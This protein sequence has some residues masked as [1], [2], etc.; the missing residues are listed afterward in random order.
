MTTSATSST[1]ILLSLAGVLTGSGVLMYCMIH[2]NKTNI[3]KNVSSEIM[4]FDPTNTAASGTPGASG[5]SGASTVPVTQP[6]SVPSH[7]VAGWFQT[8]YKNQKFT[9]TFKVSSPDAQLLPV[10]TVA[11][12]VPFVAIAK[13]FSTNFKKLNTD[14]QFP[15]NNKNDKQT[16]VAY[17]NNIRHSLNS[18][19]INV[20]ALLAR[21]SN[22]F[23]KWYVENI[24]KSAKLTDWIKNNLFNT[25]SIQ[26]QE[27]SS[28]PFEEEGDYTVIIEYINETYE[29]TEANEKDILI[30]WVTND[31]TNWLNIF[32]N[33]FASDGIK[34]WIFEK[35]MKKNISEDDFKTIPF[36]K[37]TADREV[38]VILSYISNNQA[39]LAKSIN[40]DNINKWVNFGY[41]KWKSDIVIDSSLAS[42][43][44]KKWIKDN[45]GYNA[46]PMKSDRI[47]FKSDEDKD[48]VVKYID[49]NKERFTDYGLQ[50]TTIITMVHQK[51]YEWV[52]TPSTEIMGWRDNIYKKLYIQPEKGIIKYEDFYKIPF[53][54]A[55]DLKIVEDY[56][57]LHKPR[58]NNF[59]LDSSIVTTLVNQDYIKWKTDNNLLA[60]PSASDDIK[61]WIRDN[62]GYNSI[63]YSK[64][65]NISFK[66]H[67][68]KKI[69]DTYIDNNKDRLNSFLHA[70]DTYTYRYRN[71]NRI[72]TRD[73]FPGK[74]YRFTWADE[75]DTYL[76]SQNIEKNGK[77][78]TN[79]E[80][81]IHLFN[82]TTTF[83]L[84]PKDDRTIYLT[85][86]VNQDYTKWKSDIE[87]R[88]TEASEAI[89][90][91]ILENLGYTID[92]SKFENIGFESIKDKELIDEYIKANN[93][94]LGLLVPP[95][96]I[97]KLVNQ[98]YTKWKS[99]IE[100]RNNTEASEA[101]KKWILKNLGYTID[102]KEFDKIPFE[103]DE[104]KYAVDNY[105]IQQTD[106]ITKLVNLEVLK[107]K[108]N[109]K[110]KEVTDSSRIKIWI[111][112]MQVKMNIE[113]N[114]NPKD[115]QQIPFQFKNDLIIIQTFI[116]SDKFNTYGANIN[117]VK[118]ERNILVDWELVT[119]W[120]V[121]DYKKWVSDKG[122]R[123]DEN[124]SNEIKN[125]I[126]N[127]LGYEYASDFAT[128]PLNP[129]N[130]F[131]E[132]Q[133]IFTYI[134]ENKHRLQRSLDL[135]KLKELIEKIYNPN[136][137]D[138]ASSDIQQI[139]TNQSNQQPPNQS[140]QQN[141]PNP[142][143]P[144]TQ[145]TNQP[146]NPTNQPNPKKK[147]KVFEDYYR[148]LFNEELYR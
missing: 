61:K 33:Q 52:T 22:S 99:D 63:D 123:K 133:R 18:N 50:P 134:A 81:L 47:P 83:K 129:K 39:R 15:F 139:S 117:G 131:K 109:N 96:E 11:P 126:L 79:E 101:I 21:V 46:D 147:R 100:V 40:L 136:N 8:L 5:S 14:I 84:E 130:S 67:A 28:I 125:W 20:E 36:S 105:I 90:K 10:T 120:V 2:D 13:W 107:E 112:D 115:F 86:W 45:L 98:D 17:I 102:W 124:I 94:R 78:L 142:P 62:L 145:Q 4:K 26:E 82:K 38:A 58:I 55:R 77:A 56:I 30:T 27:F 121:E 95:V 70:I 65:Q 113:F 12:P 48:V 24:I 34:T 76:H 31:Y 51:H 59:K 138:K 6:Y 25:K 88:N 111:N 29:D 64:F 128:I 137:N 72:Y 141:P 116:T 9:D 108:I 104:D 91:W 23:K 44:I 119:K 89:K 87:V 110:F 35:L 118:F 49:A 122:V 132:K 92:Y 106:R 60:N 66:T 32:N 1:A 43:E 93:E 37:E 127:K 69:V 7:L 57:E 74:G 135:E 140:T 85:E 19:G 68:D 54:F 71:E 73:S 97:S 103:S 53:K 41:T 75:L 143:N 42:P 114:F 3:M 144:T 80:K 16:I 148:E 146:N